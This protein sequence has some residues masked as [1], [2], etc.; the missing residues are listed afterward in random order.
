MKFYSRVIDKPYSV[1]EELRDGLKLVKRTCLCTFVN[2]VFETEDPKIIAKLEVKK[3]LFKT[4]KPWI[5]GFNWKTTDEGKK[6]I[7]EGERL[8]IKCKHIREWYLEQLIREAKTPKSRKPEAPVVNEKVLVSSQP[9]AVKKVEEVIEGVPNEAYLEAMKMEE[10]APKPTTKAVKI[11]Y[12]EIVRLA[13]E[14]GF[15]THKVKRK[16]L[17]KKL[18]ESGIN[19]LSR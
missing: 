12:K 10:E 14:K 17:E 2:G 8:G 7:E 4:D 16:I 9:K 6:L 19:V 1:M 15:K 18:K 3:N 5:Q 13:K 11:D